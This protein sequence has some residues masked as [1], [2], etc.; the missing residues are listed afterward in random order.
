MT[1]IATVLSA[2]GYRTHAV[3]KWDVGMASEAHHPRARGYDSWTGYW[4]HA[5]D[6]WSMSTGSCQG[7][8]PPPPP[9]P[10][11][12]SASSGGHFCLGSSP[13]LKSL[14]THH[15][16]ECCAACAATPGCAGWAG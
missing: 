9:T 13:N 2:A 4:H 12:C 1:T 7:P 14:W 10:Q 11:H 8:P 5:N 3:G 6:Y 16:E 15:S